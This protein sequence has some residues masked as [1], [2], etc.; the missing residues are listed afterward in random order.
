MYIYVYMYIYIGILYIDTLY[1]YIYIHIYIYI[2]WITGI[3][4]QS[5]HS[6]ISEFIVVK[7]PRIKGGELAER[8]ETRHV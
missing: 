4:N 7:P 6:D 1:I 5:K 2:M 8:S 3:Q